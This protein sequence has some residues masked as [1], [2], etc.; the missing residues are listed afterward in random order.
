MSGYTRTHEGD[1]SKHF[2]SKSTR[3]YIH[4]Y[5]H[6]FIHRDPGSHEYECTKCGF[7]LFVAKGREFKF[8]GDNFKC[9]GCGADKSAFKD[10][11]LSQ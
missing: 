2:V 1:C 4:T 9:T 7:T 5:T 3:S 6:S 11:S 10:N 8:F